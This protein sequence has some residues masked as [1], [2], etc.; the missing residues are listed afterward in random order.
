MPEP[1][2]GLNHGEDHPSRGE[3]PTSRGDVSASRGERPT[4][5]GDV[6]ANRGE[7]ATSRGE[8]P[9]DRGEGATNRGESPSRGSVRLY[10]SLGRKDGVTPE[11]VAEQLSSSGVS[12]SPSVIE[13][14]NTHS[15]LNLDSATAERLCQAMQG[16]QY[17][18]RAIV[19]EPARPPRRR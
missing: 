12:V 1:P 19:C 18:G 8:S 15:Y 9:A 7:S 5:R 14:M 17:N 11:V 10:V 2:T 3:S 6:L 16:R 13:L 4:D